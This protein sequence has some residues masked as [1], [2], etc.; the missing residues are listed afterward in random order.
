MADAEERVVLAGQDAIDL[1]QQGADAWNAW[2]AENPVADIDFSKV[3]FSGYGD[4]S[5]EGFR[6][7]MGEKNFSDIKFGK[8]NILF[9]NI[10]FSGGNIIF[11]G[12]EFGD[13]KFFLDLYFLAT[14]MWI[15]LILF[16]TIVT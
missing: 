10:N 6:F 16:L 9:E 13:G 15:S 3:D 2:V 4:V 5:F 7:P 1:W 12:T 8:S 14:G 11:R